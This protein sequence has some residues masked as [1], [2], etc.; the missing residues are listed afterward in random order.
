MIDLFKWLVVLASGVPSD[1]LNNNGI[2]D[3]IFQGGNGTNKSDVINFYLGWHNV[4]HTDILVV[5]KIIGTVN[6]WILLVLYHI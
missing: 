4:S 1:L 6:G 5:Q 2:V 3:K